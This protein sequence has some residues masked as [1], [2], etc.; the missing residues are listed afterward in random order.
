MNIRLVIVLSGLFLLIMSIGAWYYFWGPCGIKKVANAEAQL[1]AILNRWDDQ[2]KLASQT[3]R[4]ALAIPVSEL[5]KMRRETEALMVPSCLKNAKINLTNGMNSTIDGY[6]AFMGNS[7]DTTTGIKIQEARLSFEQFRSSLAWTN[8]CAPFCS[9]LI[10]SAVSESDER[11]K[12][13]ITLA[14]M[15]AIGT[16]VETYAVDNNEYP[17]AKD[18]VDLKAYVEPKYIDSLPQ[19]DSWGQKFLYIVSDDKYSYSI[20]SAGSD[21]QF[22]NG[23][24][25][26]HGAFDDLSQDIVFSAGEFKRYP[27]NMSP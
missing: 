1:Q 12:T 20:I 18:I 5:Q 21:G 4:I 3:S 13:K 6:L 2:N 9:G 22:D 16:V 25:A 27:R 24:W 23:T 8:S 14:D 19:F 26:T 17:P 7:D 11:E 15:R 10:L